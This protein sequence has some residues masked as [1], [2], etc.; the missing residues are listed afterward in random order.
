MKKYS[1]LLIFLFLAPITLYGADTKTVYVTDNLELPLRSSES[2]KGKIISL[3]PTGTPLTV[4]HENAKTGFSKVKLQNG[5]EGYISTRNTMPELPNRM[6]TGPNAKII[7][8]LQTENSNLKAELAKAKT[9]LAPGTTLEQSL[10]AERDRLERELNEIRKTAATQ[11]QLKTEHDDLQEQVVNTKRELEQLK[12]ENHALKDGAN[13]D[14]FLYG[15]I[16]AL[17]GVL[18]GFILP[19]LAWRRKNSWDNF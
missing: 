2:T 3:L 19:K 1:N 15:G 6:L 10:T 18:L 5:M 4:L 7:E 16:L 12:L 13:Q 14:W 17:G 9:A 11:I 8:T